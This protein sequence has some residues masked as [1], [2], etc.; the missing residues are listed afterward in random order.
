MENLSFFLGVLAI[1]GICLVYPPLLAG[2]LAI[3][4]AFLGRGGETTLSPRGTVGVIL[5]SISLVAVI[6]MFIITISM[7]LSYYGGFSNIPMDYEE[8]LRDMETMQEQYL[9]TFVVTYN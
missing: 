6:L 9:S 2:S 5:G 3:V 7:L 1:T 4:F 8:I